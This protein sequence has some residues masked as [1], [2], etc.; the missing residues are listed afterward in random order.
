MSSIDFTTVANASQ[1]LVWIHW[2]RNH[3]SCFFICMWMCPLRSHPPAFNGQ[4]ERFPWTERELG[5]RVGVRPFKLHTELLLRAAWLLAAVPASAQARLA[6]TAV[7]AGHETVTQLWVTARHVCHRAKCDAFT[8]FRNKRLI[9]GLKVR[10][11]H[12]EFYKAHLR[13]MNHMYNM[14]NR[15]S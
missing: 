9:K 3:P 2:L 6:A 4:W 10:L 13:V 1:S 11:K 14:F 7:W 15:L 12:G 5:V 8:D